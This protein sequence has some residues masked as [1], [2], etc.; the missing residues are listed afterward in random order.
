MAFDGT[1]LYDPDAGRLLSTIHG[2]RPVTE[3]AHSLFDVTISDAKNTARVALA[4]ALTRLVMQGRLHLHSLVQVRSAAVIVVVLADMSDAFCLCLNFR[5]S[6]TGLYCRMRR[7]WTTAWWWLFWMLRFIS[8][9]PRIFLPRFVAWWGACCGR[10]PGCGAVAVTLC[11]RFRV[12]PFTLSWR[13]WWTRCGKLDRKRGAP[14]WVPV[15]GL[16]RCV[17]RMMFP[18]CQLG[19]RTPNNTHF[20]PFQPD[21]SS[22]AWCFLRVSLPAQVLMAPWVAFDPTW[23]CVVASLVWGA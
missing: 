19:R 15:V 8:T 10:V 22:S 1:D 23:C 11:P 2:A 6:R 4:P 21:C 17:A 20:S 7:L 14:F 18:R 3:A 16:S 12:L 13:Q 5:S 9:T